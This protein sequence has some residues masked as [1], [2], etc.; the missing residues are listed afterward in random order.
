[1]TWLYREAFSATWVNIWGKERCFFLV[2]AWLQMQQRISKAWLLRWCYL[3]HEQVQ[4]PRTPQSKLH[5]ISRCLIT[6]LRLSP[7]RSWVS[8][9]PELLAQ[10]LKP[11]QSDTACMLPGR[12]LRA[13]ATWK[14][15]TPGKTPR[16]LWRRKVS[17]RICLITQNGF[18]VPAKI[19]LHCQRLGSDAAIPCVSRDTFLS[20]KREMAPEKQHWGLRDRL[21]PAFGLHPQSGHVMSTR[22]QFYCSQGLKTV[23]FT[24]N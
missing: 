21:P 6:Q 19:A 17:S 2:Y 10:I 8:L 22:E 7:L 15:A 18:P 23:A 3:Q 20:W 9:P 1:M 4:K 16:L 13:S 12:E 24:E 14:V 5:K 11:F